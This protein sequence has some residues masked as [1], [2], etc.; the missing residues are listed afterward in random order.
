L[1][2]EYAKL[3]SE[4]GFQF[5]V[6]YLCPTGFSKLLTLNEAEIITNAN[7][8]IVSVFETTAGRT[9]K[10]SNAIDDARIANQAAIDAKQPKGTVIY[11]AVD[12]EAI[13]TDMDLI[14][15]YLK[16]AQEQISGYYVGVYGSYNVIEEMYKRKACNYFWQTYAW[17]GG[18][19]SYHANLYQYE[20]A[21]HANGIDYDLDSSNNS[22]G[23]WNLKMIE[24]ENWEWIMLESTIKSLRKKNILTDDSWVSKV[25]N[26]TITLTELSFIL[27]VMVDRIAK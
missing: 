17:S 24:L 8:N 16:Q 21:L 7:L 3:F 4:Q 6:R 19:V 27:M 25:E 1:T 15:S 12:Y 10:P 23:W 2:E 20:N 22:V 5:V 13:S 26:K 11:F 18:K 9:R 14:E